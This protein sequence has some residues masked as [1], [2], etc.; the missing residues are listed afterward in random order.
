[1]IADDHRRG[2]EGDSREVTARKKKK[3]R[4]MEC[5]RCKGGVQ[6]SDEFCPD[7]GELL[8]EGISCTNHPDKLAKGACVI[9]CAAYCSLCGNRRGH[10][11]L[12]GV[13]GHYE[14]YQGM[15]RVYGTNDAAQAGYAASCLEQRQLHPM[16]YSRKASPIHM[17]G[18]EYTLLHMSGETSGHVVNEIKLMVPVQEVL[19]AEEILQ[20]LEML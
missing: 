19:V 20:E 10:P 14:I 12:C 5:P 2:N 7:C 8:V 6:G 18:S 4:I 1:M 15:A 3:G 17:G 9:C 16:L 13:H 11:F